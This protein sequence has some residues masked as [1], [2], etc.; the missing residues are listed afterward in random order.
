MDKEKVIG[1]VRTD[2][3]LA[4]VMAEALG[5]RGYQ[6]VFDDSELIDKIREGTLS[7]DLVISGGFAGLDA[8]QE[9]H[10]LGQKVL[11]W[12]ALDYSQEAAEMGIPF[13]E[14]DGSVDSLF[15]A[16]SEMFGSQ[17]QV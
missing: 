5:D 9:L 16:L 14:K 1:F 4:A 12:S 13:V 11:I 8:A 15:E 17:G 7:P 10:S 3:H 6:V 2:N